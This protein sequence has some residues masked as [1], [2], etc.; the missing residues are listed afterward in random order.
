MGAINKILDNYL[1]L[2]LKD[3]FNYYYFLTFVN[4]IAV[5]VQSVDRIRTRSIGSSTNSYNGCRCRCERE[6]DESDSENGFD[7]RKHFQRGVVQ[8]N[9]WLT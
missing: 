7:K 4:N 5:E 6:E 8:C 2:N 9:A 1:F 3:I